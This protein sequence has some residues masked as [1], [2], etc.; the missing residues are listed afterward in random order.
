MILK[1]GEPITE[2]QVE[3]QMRKRKAEYKI[4]DI[5]K[6]GLFF[7]N[8][9]EVKYSDMKR[10]YKNNDLAQVVGRTFSVE[11]DVYGGDKLIIKGIN[12][13]YFYENGTFDLS[14]RYAE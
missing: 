7:P 2:E 1:R 5:Q 12:T 8:N 4:L 9:D 6:E 10:I 14:V 13:L 11:D 3:E